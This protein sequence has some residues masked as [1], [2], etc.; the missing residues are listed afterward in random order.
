[1]SS[2]N[3][4]QELLNFVHSPKYTVQQSEKELEE[5]WYKGKYAPQIPHSQEGNLYYTEERI[6]P[7]V[8][9]MDTHHSR[10]QEYFL[11]TRL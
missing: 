7:A 8:R 1:M 9:K 2:T 3:L 6:S 11:I 5:V 4:W 10:C